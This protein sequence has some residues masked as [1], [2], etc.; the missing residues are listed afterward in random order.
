MS[1]RV[2][3]SV[4]LAAVLALAATATAQST[5]RPGIRVQVTRIGSAG[6]WS[7]NAFVPVPPSRTTVTA[8]ECPTYE[9][10]GRAASGAVREVWL[11]M[12]SAAGT[13]V[14]L[15]MTASDTLGCGEVALELVLEDGSTLRPT[16]GS[17]TVTLQPGDLH[18]H[19]T[20]TITN[21]DGAPTTLVADF[22]LR[23]R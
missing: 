23:P 9:G 6:G 17:A 22:A 15:P 16:M 7:G 14:S 3:R 4:L 11:R 5:A 12:T 2:L 21:A 8:G 18:G 20:G 1:P 10:R 13:D 19:V